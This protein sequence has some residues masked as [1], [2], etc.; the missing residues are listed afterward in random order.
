MKP[1]TKQSAACDR[2]NN[3]LHGSNITLT[4][5]VSRMLTILLC[6]LVSYGAFSQ[7]FFYV[8][9]SGSDANNGGSW[10]TAFESIQK[11]LVVATPGSKILVAAGVYFPDEGFNAVDN[12][13]SSTFTLKNQVSI[14]GGFEPEFGIDDLNDIRLQRSP[15]GLEGRRQ[16]ERG[17]M[18]G[19][20]PALR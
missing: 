10:A 6:F 3:V 1:N 5:I 13:R 18:H 14:Y 9:P 12:L 2:V 8:K 11:A 15:A 20:K 16:R 7:P 4:F 19:R 17:A